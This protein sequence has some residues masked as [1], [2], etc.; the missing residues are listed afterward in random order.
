MYS[1]YQ[2]F[3][4]KRYLRYLYVD[5]TL[6]KT[7]VGMSDFVVYSIT[8]IQGNCRSYYEILSTI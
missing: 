5:V 1:Y 3:E 4:N 7:Y 6:H 2:L 8:A